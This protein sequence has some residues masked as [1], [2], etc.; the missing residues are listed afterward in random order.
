MMF[1]GIINARRKENRREDDAL[2]IYLDAG[3]TTPTI[4]QVGSFLY[5]VN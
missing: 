1:D 5:G 4:I 2:Q 3:E